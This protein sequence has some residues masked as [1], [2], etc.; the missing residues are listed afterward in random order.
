MACIQIRGGAFGF[1]WFPFEAKLD[2]QVAAF[3]VTVADLWGKVHWKKIQELSFW[4][5][6]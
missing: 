2:R 3:S 1:L 5:L 4:W 6:V